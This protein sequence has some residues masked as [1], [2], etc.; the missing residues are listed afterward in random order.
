MLEFS[1]RTKNVHISS[2]MKSN[3]KSS[4]KDLIEKEKNT[5]RTKRKKNQ[6]MKGLKILSNI[7][8]KSK[9]KKS[10]YSLGEIKIAKIHRE[11]TRPLK[12][13]EK[14][15]LLTKDEIK[16]N[17][18]P[19]CGLPTK[20][21]GKLDNY[22]MCDNPDEFLNCGKGVILYFSFFKFF[23]FV[24]IIGTICISFFDC[25]FSYTYYNELKKFCNNLN[26]L[27][28]TKYDLYN[29][30]YYKI[31]INKINEL[32]CDVYSREG[33]LE[34]H[35]LIDSFFFKI[36]L[37]NYRNYKIIFNEIFGINNSKS[38]I[39]NLNLINFL[40]LISI[41]IIYLIYIF[42]IHNKT[43]S[44]NYF[45]HSVSDYSIFATDLNDIYKKFE[46]N[47]E[48]I[49]EKEIEYSKTKNKLEEKIYQDKLG[50]KPD[51]NMLKIDLFK[52]FLKK[53]VFKKENSLGEYNVKRID[54]CYKLEE[55]INLQKKSE[56]LEEKIQK[57][58][59]DE[60]IIEKNNKNNL[61]GN[62]RIYYNSCCCLGEE[63]SLEEIKRKKK[64]CEKKM[65]KLITSSKENPSEHFCGSAFISFDTIQEQ[66][67][68]LKYIHKK[69]CCYNLIEDYVTL[70]KMFYYYMT[71][72]CCCCFCLCFCKCCCSCCSCCCNGDE[73]SLNYVKKK[74]NFE[75]ASEP[76]DIIFENL[77]ISQTKKFKN[78]ICVVSISI[79][80]SGISLLINKM[81]YGMQQ[82]MEEDFR[83][84]DRQFIVNIYSFII[85][86]FTAI[87]DVI[88][89]IVIEKIIKCEKSY[90]L[91]N[92]YGHYGVNLTF[93]W[94]LN[95]GLIPVI[96]D[97][98]TQS[99][100][101]HEVLTNNLITKFLF[102]SFL[103]PLMWTMNAKF[104][105]KKIKQCIIE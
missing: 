58:E 93:F 82:N 66:E 8:I 56:N 59:Y 42:F 61:K 43:N 31:K 16:N 103:T 1:K 78:L 87:M 33:I 105:Y 57:I 95:S 10:N 85:T 74:I 76:E 54:L 24:S 67:N 34:F 64:M 97:V 13:I 48:F 90:T 49:K 6:T 41:F 5:K 60:S 38:T 89:E 62:K 30:Y 23:I 40:C 7:E 37:V 22:K 92:F 86:I 83:R 35:K 17:S 46:E 36:S 102:N 21:E 12:K 11:A 15:F 99:R 45:V 71:V 81:L 101:E 28:I 19:C 100:E 27:N 73:N 104:V 29:R 91:T 9:K 84:T 88:L 32:K 80:I 72:Y 47:L 75:K 79:I 25:F 63:E 77:E 55:I 18:C 96:C 68:Y 52:I 98:I 94:F 70:F 20:I 44:L 53:K 51:N 3:S 2:F 26:K 69:K 4:F 39:V 50:F 14:D 65:N